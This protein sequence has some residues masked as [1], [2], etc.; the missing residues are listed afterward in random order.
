MPIP[1]GL[2]DLTEMFARLGA[3]DA[4]GWAS[5]QVNEGIEQL[6][7]FLFLRQAWSHVIPD[8]DTHWIAH[9]V[10][11]AK[12]KPSALEVK[13]KIQPRLH[14]VGRLTNRWSGRVKDKVP[15]S[16]VGVRAAQLNR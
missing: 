2:K 10:A 11:R 15:S 5:S 14:S 8:G 12:A 16:T 7:R 1:K 4:S 6:H 3:P 9:E 13:V